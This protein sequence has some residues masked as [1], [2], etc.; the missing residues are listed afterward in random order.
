MDI[1]ASLCIPLSHP[2]LSGHCCGLGPEALPAWSLKALLGRSAPCDVRRARVFGSLGGT[3][4]RW[5][6][7]R[8][9]D[10]GHSSQPHVVSSHLQVWSSLIRI[11]YSF[12][13]TWC[14]RCG[15]AS[16]LPPSGPAH[17]R[18]AVGRF[19]PTEVGWCP[20]L[21]AKHHPGQAACVLGRRVL[22]KYSVV[23]LA[24]VHPTKRFPMISM[25]FGIA[26]DSVFAQWFLNSRKTNTNLLELF[27]FCAA[28]VRSGCVWP[29]WSCITYVT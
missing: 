18:A 21:C 4:V 6:D 28:M 8:L 16:R 25:C 24:L 2:L 3:G 12:C 7:V 5:D 22:S 10:S 14:V 27:I 13:P 26:I 17:A 15:E 1:C 23:S 29:F 20:E 19:V 11:P 9:R